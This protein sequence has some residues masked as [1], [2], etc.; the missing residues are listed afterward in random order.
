MHYIIEDIDKIVSMLPVPVTV[1]IHLSSL[2]II[3]HILAAEYSTISYPVDNS[4]SLY[5]RFPEGATYS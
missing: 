4:H 1:N 2:T 5:S 3:E